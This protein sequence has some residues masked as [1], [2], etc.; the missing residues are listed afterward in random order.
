VQSQ[1]QRQLVIVNTTAT[2]KVV[3]TGT[4]NPTYQWQK[5]E[6]NI[7]G[8]TSATYTIPSSQFADTGLYSV[9]VTSGNVSFTSTPAQL[10]V[11]PAGTPLPPIIILAQP[12][13]QEV[14]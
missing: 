2:F 3:A 13:D 8:A 7:N 6:A 9:V 5:N 11:F 4:P 10:Q 1:P 14:I 12:T